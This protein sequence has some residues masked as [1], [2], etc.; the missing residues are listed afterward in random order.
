MMLTLSIIH[1]LYTTRID[2]TLAFPQADTDITIYMEIL[3]G[4]TVSEKDFVCLLLK[5][6]YGLKQAA[7]TWFE[8]LQDTLV[9]SESKGDHSFTQSKIDTCIF[10]KEGITMITWVNNCLIFAKEK[11]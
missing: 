1:K 11:A 6:L 9:M 10:Y 7:K 2:F 4:C 3:H 5:N 8:Y